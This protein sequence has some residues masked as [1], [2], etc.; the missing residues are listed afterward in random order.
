VIF[1]LLQHTTTSRPKSTTS[2]DLL[3]PRQMLD[4]SLLCARHLMRLP[5][6]SAAECARAEAH[7]NRAL[8]LVASLDPDADSNAAQDHTKTTD[9]LRAM[10]RQLYSRK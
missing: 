9:E 10:L 4:A 2:P 8:V 6:A 7:I 3:I 1:I 5:R